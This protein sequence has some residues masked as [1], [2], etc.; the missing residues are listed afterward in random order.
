VHNEEGTVDNTLGGK[1]A[2][3]TGAAG[4]IGRIYA[5]ALAASGA[6]VVIADL[7]EEGALAVASEL[8]DQGRAAIGVR[9]DITD[10]DSARAMAAAAT[11]AYGGVDILVNNAPSW[12]SSRRCH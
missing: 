12:Q 10:P 5:S 6:S 8:V 2:I 11:E 4:G 1:V 3:V 7:N 9:V